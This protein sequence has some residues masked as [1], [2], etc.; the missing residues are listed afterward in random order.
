MKR[1]TKSKI[2]VGA[3]VLLLGIAIFMT[4][5]F[6]AAFQ[7]HLFLVAAFSAAW[8][9]VGVGGSLTILLSTMS[10]G[11]ALITPAATYAKR[12]FCFLKRKVGGGHNDSSDDS[13]NSWSPQQEIAI[14]PQVLSISSGRQKVDIAGPDYSSD[15][16]MISS[17]RRIKGRGRRHRRSILI[18][19]NGLFR[20]E[21]E[22]AKLEPK[23]PR[24]KNMR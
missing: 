5:S 8:V 13:T 19:A 21:Q 18:R 14:S 6:I 10:A 7:P 1:S 11:M 20:Q 16:E 3:G 2:A 4:M 15:S 9:K 23:G 17:T 12:L 22:D 24:L